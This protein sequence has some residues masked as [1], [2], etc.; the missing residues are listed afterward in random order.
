L[1]RRE[2]IERRSDRK[3]ET[4]QNILAEWADETYL[5]ES[6]AKFD[7]D[8][9]SDTGISAR[10]IDWSDAAGFLITVIAIRDEAGHPWG[11][12]AFRANTTDERHYLDS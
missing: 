7:P 12:T 2:H 6:A 9:A 10:T 1:H 4:E 11:A 3:G 8:Y 5:D